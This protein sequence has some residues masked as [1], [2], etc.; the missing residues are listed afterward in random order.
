MRRLKKLPSTQ[1]LKGG[2]WNALL[3]WLK[4]WK[5]SMKL[6]LSAR[7]RNHRI[8]RPGRRRHHET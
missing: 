6:R 5:A 1:Y 7:K 4:R 3:D 2:D 8:S